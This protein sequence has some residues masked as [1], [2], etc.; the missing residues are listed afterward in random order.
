MILN[1]L[2]AL[3]SAQTGMS[4]ATTKGDNYTNIPSDQTTTKS[5]WYNTYNETGFSNGS[6]FYLGI[7]IGSGTTPPR[8]QTTNSRMLL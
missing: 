3:L 5:T 6:E 7:C 1:N 4:M 8:G 2:F